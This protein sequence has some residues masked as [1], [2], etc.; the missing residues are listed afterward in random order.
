MEY[1]KGLINIICIT[2]L[3]LFL[4]NHLTTLHIYL[5]TPWEVPIPKLGTNILIAAVALKGIKR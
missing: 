5:V 4:V 3:F 1:R 2:F